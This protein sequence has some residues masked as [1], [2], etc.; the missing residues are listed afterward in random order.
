V[1]DAWIIAGLALDSTLGVPTSLAESLDVFE[2]RGGPVAR[3]AASRYLGGDTDP[4]AAQAWKEHALP[5]YG[6][7]NDGDMAARRSRCLINDEVQA[8]FRRGGCGS[9][10][11]TEHLN[12]IRCPTLILAGA[13]DP[14]TPA[15]AA[16]RLAALLVNAAVETEV[17]DNVGHSVF[18]QA[19]HRAFG[20]LRRFLATHHGPACRAGKQ[21]GRGAAARHR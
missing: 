6:G 20:V 19:P 1:K 16:G 5:L 8:H 4:A 3:E 17:F 13:D 11:M 10:D 2:R 7:A 9:A 18:R 21:S 15:A 14:V 12:A